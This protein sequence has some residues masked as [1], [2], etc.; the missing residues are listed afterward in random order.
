MTTLSVVNG[1]VTAKYGIYWEAGYNIT[2]NNLPD[3]LLY[4]IAI[5]L[6]LLPQKY[7]PN[8]LNVF[9]ELN[10]SYIFEE[11]GNNLFLSPGIQYIAGRKLLFWIP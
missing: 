6:P 3:N 8:Q 11:V 9:L 7:P 10:G 4:N 1:Y 5:G 2:G